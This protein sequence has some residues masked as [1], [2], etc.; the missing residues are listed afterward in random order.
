[1]PL[2]MLTQLT[3]GCALPT[4]RTIRGEA[5]IAKRLKHGQKG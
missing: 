2:A 4:G 3:G 5:T 1:L